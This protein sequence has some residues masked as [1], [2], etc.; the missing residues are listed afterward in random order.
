MRLC[1][2]R[3]RQ[4]AGRGG[5]V[6]EAASRDRTGRRS[7]GALTAN[8]RRNYLSFAGVFLIFLVS[9]LPVT[10]GLK[11]GGSLAG[12]LSSELIVTSSSSDS[13]RWRSSSACCFSFSDMGA[14]E[15]GFARN[16]NC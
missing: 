15:F 9:A 7:M 4:R 3:G 12:K 5:A 8:V 11:D 16:D 14:S 13:I 1:L 10:P 2:N 6:G